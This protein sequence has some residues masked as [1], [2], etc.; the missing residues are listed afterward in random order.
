MRIVSFQITAPNGDIYEAT[1]DGDTWTVTFPEGEFRH[2]GTVAQVRAEI[3]R[4]IADPLVS[5]P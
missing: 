1:R 4:R 3:R 2:H 5:C